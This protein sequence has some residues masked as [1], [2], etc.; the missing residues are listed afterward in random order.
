MSFIKLRDRISHESEI[1]F[2]IENEPVDLHV[3]I[4]STIRKKKI[5]ELRAKSTT[6]MFIG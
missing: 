2:K 6:I 1:F 3:L 4:G 5:F